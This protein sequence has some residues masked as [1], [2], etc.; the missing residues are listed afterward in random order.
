MLVLSRYVL[1]GGV[2]SAH[3]GV[4]QTDKRNRLYFDLPDGGRVTLILDDALNSF[5][6]ELKIKVSIDAPSDVRILR[7]ELEQGDRS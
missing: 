5:E 1:G 3:P 6:G 2:R 4:S 7:G